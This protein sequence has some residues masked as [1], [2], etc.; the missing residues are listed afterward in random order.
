MLNIPSGRLTGSTEGARG[1]AA[2]R[3]SVASTYDLAAP[4][5]ADGGAAWHIPL[6]ATFHDSTDTDVSP[7]RSPLRLFEN[8]AL[9]G[10]GHALHDRIRTAG[11]GLYSFWKSGLWFSTSDGSNPN[12]NGRVYDIQLVDADANATTSAS[13]DGAR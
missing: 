7:A 9:L 5:T 3:N 13:D 8:G 12:S 10:P 6:P 1:I 4:Y 11:G 2:V